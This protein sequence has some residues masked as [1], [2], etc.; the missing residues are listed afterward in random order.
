[1]TTLALL[2]AVIVLGT[3]LP[4]LLRDRPIRLW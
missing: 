4:L 3:R 1:M 2:L